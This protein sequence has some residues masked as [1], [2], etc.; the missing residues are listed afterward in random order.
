M[1][2]HGPRTSSFKLNVDITAIVSLLLAFFGIIMFSYS[3][4]HVFIAEAADILLS[5]YVHLCLW[6]S[7]G[8]YFGH[9]YN[10]AAGV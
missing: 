6:L 5:V 1:E 8:G 2:S 10:L 3:T 7:C 9:Y 4:F